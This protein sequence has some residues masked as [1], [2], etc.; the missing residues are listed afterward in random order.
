MPHPGRVYDP[1]LAVTPPLH[2]LNMHNMTPGQ[3]VLAQRQWVEKEYARNTR[4]KAAV[5]KRALVARLCGMDPP[6][7]DEDI[8]R[9]ADANLSWIQALR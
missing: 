7:D 9:S 8:L 2:M 4:L 3:Y 1:D 5:A 6:P